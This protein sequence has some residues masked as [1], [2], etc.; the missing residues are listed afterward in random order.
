MQFVCLI[1]K[2]FFPSATSW[3]CQC[4]FG[5]ININ[6]FFL[7][8]NFDFSVSISFSIFN[9]RFPNLIGVFLKFISFLLNINFRFPS[10]NLY[11][12]NYTL[13]F[14]NPIGVFFRFVFLN[15]NFSFSISIDVPRI[16]I[17][18]LSEFLN[19]NLFLLNINFVFRIKMSFSV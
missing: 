4:Q 19:F 11:I 9:L 6:L 5:F 18:Y 13:S 10:I 1:L 14:S 3:V 17:Q 2:K 7:S 15:K 16:Q 8:V 12:L